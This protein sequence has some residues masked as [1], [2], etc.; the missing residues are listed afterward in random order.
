MNMK[1]AY[2]G[3][4]GAYSHIASMRVFPNQEYI[5]CETFEEAMNRVAEGEIDIAMIPVE[6][7]NAGRVSDVH[8][9]LPKTGLHIV[10]E[11]FL[12]IEHQLLGLND[13]KLEDIVAAFFLKRNDSLSISSIFLSASHDSQ[14]DSELW[15]TV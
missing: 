9:L 6:N 11:Y 15:I 10:G 8:F 1:I 7:S 14:K 4:A 3:V 12:R 5:P 2:Q 13:A